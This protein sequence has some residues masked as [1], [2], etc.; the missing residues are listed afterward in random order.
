M[1]KLKNGFTKNILYLFLLIVISLG[2][3]IVIGYGCGG[4]GNSSNDDSG[5]SGGAT[6]RATVTQ[7][8]VY[9][10]ISFITQT[11]PGCSKGNTTE[12]STASLAYARTVRSVMNI[13]KELMHQIEFSYHIRLVRATQADPEVF[14][15]DCEGTLDG[16]VTINSTA[17]D[18]TGIFSG[19][20]L[21]DR[22]CQESEETTVLVDGDLNISGKM[23]TET[24]EFTEVTAFSN[25][26][27]VQQG[28]ESYT[29]E[30]NVSAA[31]NNNQTTIRIPNFSVQDETTNRTFT[32][33]NL[34][35]T[36]T[37]G[38]TTS[39]IQITGRITH[40]EEGYIDINTT[41][42]LFVTSD[43]EITSG[44]LTITG[45]DGTSVVVTPT[46]D[47]PFQFDFKADTDGDGIFDYEECLDCSEV[48]LNLEF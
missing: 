27:S 34:I 9:E 40:S 31:L 21:F 3:M 39:Q 1:I 44:Q 22:Y 10:T 13:A 45:G 11:V 12:R 30:F 38:N 16:T 14:K 4:D 7:K 24:D 42:T 18:E 25:G 20:L 2:L 29:V 35:I 36:A 15:G 41:Q 43:G 19:A 48:N 47:N 28:E 8:S 26:I 6:T 33:T 32:I 17:N 37:E 5:N 23:D 46:G